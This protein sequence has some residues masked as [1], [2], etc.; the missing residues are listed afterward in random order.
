MTNGQRTAAIDGLRAMLRAYRRPVAAAVVIAR[1]QALPPDLDASEFATRC[2][3]IAKHVW[4]A[5]A[6]RALAAEDAAHTALLAAFTDSVA[7]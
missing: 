3:E 7:H 6:R 2:A 1:V 5:E 4:E